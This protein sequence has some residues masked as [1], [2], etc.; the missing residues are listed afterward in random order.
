MAYRAVTRDK[1][2]STGHTVGVCSWIPTFLNA[3]KAGQVY[4]NNLRVAVVGDMY[5]DHIGV[6]CKVW[7]KD[8]LRALA[9]G[10][11]SV[12]ANGIPVC[13]IRDPITCGDFAAQGSRNVFV[14]G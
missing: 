14:G 10:S 7:H 2:F 5:V 12:Y 6:P 8:M 3:E 1:D 4:A 9:S 13:R 11:S